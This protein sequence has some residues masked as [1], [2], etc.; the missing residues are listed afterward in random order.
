MFADD[1]AVH[2]TLDLHA[3]SGST[4]ISNA[5]GSLRRKLLEAVESNTTSS[6]PFSESAF[7]Q[8]VVQGSLPLAITAHSADVIASILKV[9]GTVD[10]AITSTGGDGGIRIVIIGGAESFIV[11]DELAAAKVGVVLSPLLSYRTTWDQR[12]ALTGAPLTNGTA[13]D[14]LIKAGVLVAIGLEEDWVVRDLGLLAGIA[15]KNSGGEIDETQA[16]DLVGANVYQ[17]LGLEEDKDDVDEF[18]VFEG[19]PLEVGSHVRAVGTGL[20]EVKVFEYE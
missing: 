4:S 9:K 1:A 8:K 18:V 5:V 14:R 10:S 20:G 11:A 17:L 12:R 15:S 2:Y 3:K 16:L 7:L 13:V 19:S 6:D